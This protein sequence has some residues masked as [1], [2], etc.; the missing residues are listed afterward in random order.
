M[1]QFCILFCTD[2]RL[3]FLTDYANL[4]ISFFDLFSTVSE[5]AEICALGDRLRSGEFHLHHIRENIVHAAEKFS[6]FKTAFI[7]AQI[8]DAAGMIIITKFKI[9]LWS[10]LNDINDP[11]IFI[12]A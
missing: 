11:V 6:Q 1:N 5:I 2:D 7:P 3:H 10:S 4:Y 12:S 8:T 9:I